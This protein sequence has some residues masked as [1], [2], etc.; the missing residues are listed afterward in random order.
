MI[1]QALYEYYERKA[2]DQQ[3]D[4]ARVGFEWKELPFLIVI[5]KDGKAVRLEDTREKDGKKI[6]GKSFLLPKSL[7]RTG[8]KGWETAFLLWDHLGYVLGYP[9]ADGE[10]ERELAQKQLGAF[11]AKLKSLPEFVRQDEGVAAVLRFYEHEEYK[12]VCTFEN[13]AECEKINGCNLS[14]KIDGDNELVLSRNVVKEYQ[15]TQAIVPDED[16]TYSALCLISGKFDIIQRVHSA[17]PILGGQSTGKLVG[18]QKNSGFDSYG[19]EQG[20]NAPICKYAHAAYTTALNTLIKSKTNK[21]IL[22][23]MTIVFWSQKPTALEPAFSLIFAEPRKDDPDHEVREV[24][25][26]YE[27]ITS[28]KLLTENQNRFYVL[29]LAPNAARISVRYWLDGTVKDFAEKLKQHFDDLEIERG[30]KDDEYFS[31]LKL[32]SNT[33]L[34]YKISNVPPNLP[35]AVVKAVLEG[36]PYPVSLLHSCVRRIR[37]EQQVTR[38]RAA[39]LKAC[40]NRF[41]RFHHNTEQEEIIMSLDKNNLNPAYRLGRLFAVLERIQANALNIETIRERY[42]GA[43]SSTPVSVFPKL[44]KLK[45]HHLAKL[46]ER[47]QI[48]FEKLIG[49]ILD[50]LDGSGDM[51]RQLSL[52]DQARFAIGYYHQRQDLFKKPTANQ[53]TNEATT[54]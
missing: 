16:E 45:N 31:L 10:K 15:Q 6:V 12:R 50:G 24:K 34:D 29:G 40:I 8:S 3:S 19:K 4:I 11:I 27:S 26:L 42:Y 52:N 17:T 7:V 41:N 53:A 25:Q 51:P 1:L 37:A 33:A 18:F 5:T 13:W 9:K 22:G 48:F 38:V 21:V 23:D 54:N 35:A 14:F 2:D 49:E 28:G 32:L 44:L 46:D 47:N 36:T 39:I 20:A 43:A 30:P